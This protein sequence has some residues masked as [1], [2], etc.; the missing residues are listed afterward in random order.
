[1]FC[2][3]SQT[4]LFEAA[5]SDSRSVHFTRLI[6]CRKDAYSTNSRAVA[7]SVW[8]VTW[9]H[10]EGVYTHHCYRSREF[11]YG[12]NSRIKL[13]SLK[14]YVWYWRH[15]IW[16]HSKLRGIGSISNTPR[17]SHPRL[18]T[19]CGYVVTPLP[20]STFK[21]CTLSAWSIPVIALISCE[22][23]S[24]TAYQWAAVTCREH[25]AGRCD[26]HYD[27]LMTNTR[28]NTKTSQN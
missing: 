7:L 25:N 16:I 4:C 9:R 6:Q 28:L 12:E 27:T 10:I 15:A 2:Y 23:W 11:V 26:I 24:I 21:L 18:W 17:Y 20:S 8:Y 22:T 19:G 3:S 1:M 14:T 13:T 5:I